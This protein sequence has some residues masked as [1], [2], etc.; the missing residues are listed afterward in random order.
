MYTDVVAG[1]LGA[2]R[3]LP[4]LKKVQNGAPSSAQNMPLAYIE[5]DTLERSTAGQLTS[6]KYRVLVTVVVPFQDNILAED[7]IAPFV[8]SVPAAI[9]ADATLDGR[10]HLA[11]VPTAQSGRTV[12]YLEIAGVLC[13]AVSFTVD[14]LEKQAYRTEGF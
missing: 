6:N 2:L 7:Q 9:D 13:R 1:L 12:G 3:T 5:F 4:T 10:V 14:V 8:N 11:R